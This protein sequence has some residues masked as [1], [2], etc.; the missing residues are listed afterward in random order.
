MIIG[1][2]R[3]PPVFCSGVVLSFCAHSLIELG[4]NALWVQLTVGLAGLAL[5]TTVT[6]ALAGRVKPAPMRIGKSA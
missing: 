5:M 3:S 6:Y 2:K 1:G 4:S